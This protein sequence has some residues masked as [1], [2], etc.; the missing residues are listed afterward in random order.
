[1]VFYFRR[2]YGHNLPF[3]SFYKDKEQSQ[4]LSMDKYSNCLRRVEV[5]MVGA[6]IR[7]RDGMRLVMI[8][9]GAHFPPACWISLVATTIWALGLNPL[10]LES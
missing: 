10:L 1:M 6:R 7:S 4:L 3:R 5:S 9:D 8:G 2:P